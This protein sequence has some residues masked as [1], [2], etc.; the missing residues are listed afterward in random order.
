MTVLSN[1]KVYATH[2]H[3]CSYLEGREATTL[4]VDPDTKIDQHAYSQLADIGFRRSGA[5]VYR[6]HCQGCNACVPARIP[7]DKFKLKRSQRRIW[8][9]NQDLHITRVEDITTD[10]YYGLYERYICERHIDGDMYPPSREQYQTFLSDE[11]GV[12]EFYCFRDKGKPVAV[13][14]IDTMDNGLSAIYTFF[15]PSYERRSLGSFAILWQIEQTKKLGLSYV[16]LGYWIKNCR[17]MSYKISYRPLEL[18]IDGRW[19]VLN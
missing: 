4:F 3:K 12:T 18:F 5:H 2:P 9:R 17:K 16:Y 13:A 15:D 10:E 1:L 7:V 14:V 6:P 8:N 11:I 19:L